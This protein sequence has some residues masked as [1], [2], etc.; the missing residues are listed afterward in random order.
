M[1]RLLATMWL[2]LAK[3]QLEP[4]WRRV[5]S[6]ANISDPVSRGDTALATRLGWHQVEGPWDEVYTLLA[7][8]TTSMSKAKKVSEQMASLCGWVRKDGGAHK[9]TYMVD[10]TDGDPLVHG[11]SCDSCTADPSKR[12]RTATFAK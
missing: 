4:Y 8:A 1:N 3:I 12:R 7:E 5:T 6:K 11:R 2:L 9:R 10:S